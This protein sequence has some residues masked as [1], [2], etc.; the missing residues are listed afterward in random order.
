MKQRQTPKAKIKHS[1]WGYYHRL[2]REQFPGCTVDEMLER[3][4]VDELL[5]WMAWEEMNDKAQKDA[6]KK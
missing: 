5:R 2:A 6:N 3:L 4:S 1:E